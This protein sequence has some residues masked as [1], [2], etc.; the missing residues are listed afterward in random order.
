MVIER[1][2]QAV[3]R[4]LGRHKLKETVSTMGQSKDRDGAAGGPEEDPRIVGE[5]QSDRAVSTRS[6]SRGVK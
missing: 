1:G 3:G 5:G 2:V 4:G 6:G